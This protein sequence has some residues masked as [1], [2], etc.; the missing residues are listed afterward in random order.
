MQMVEHAQSV[1]QAESAIW[2]DFTRLVCNTPNLRLSTSTANLYSI[3][4]RYKFHLLN[5]L[6][7][8]RSCDRCQGYDRNLKLLF[9]RGVVVAVHRYMANNDTFPFQ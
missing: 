3:L 6:D 2:S 8:F 1:E 5:F 9:A 7:M 4:L